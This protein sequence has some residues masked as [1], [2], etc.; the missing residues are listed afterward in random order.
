[1]VYVNSDPAGAGCTASQFAVQTY[2]LS[3]SA[4]VPPPVGATATND[5]AFNFLV[6]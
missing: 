5:A 1:M 6:T 3:T 2:T 4:G